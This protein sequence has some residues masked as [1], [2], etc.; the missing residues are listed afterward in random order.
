MPDLSQE[1]ARAE[2][3][4]D[5][6]MGIYAQSSQE[7]LSFKWRTVVAMLTAWGA[8]PFPLTIEKV[9]M[10]G[11]SLKTGGYQSAP[12]YLSLYRTTGARDGA[13]YWP[14]PGDGLPRRGAVVCQRIG[15]TPSRPRRC[16]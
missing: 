2:A 16:H 5:F 1:A 8:V 10:L 12:G 3:L 13:G 6:R 9:A 15:S 4:R 11:A 14:G 7:S